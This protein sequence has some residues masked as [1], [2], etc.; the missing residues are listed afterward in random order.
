MAEGTS[1]FPPELDE[2]SMADIN[3]FDNSALKITLATYL[4]LK[5]LTFY[6]TRG[7]YIILML[8]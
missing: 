4:F 1:L 6:G 3:P 5:F 2:Q 7:W 8:W